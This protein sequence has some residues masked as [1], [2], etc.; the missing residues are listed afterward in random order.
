MTNRLFFFIS[1]GVAGV[2]YGVLCIIAG[3]LGEYVG[4][5]FGHP[6]VGAG[7]ASGLIGF[8]CGMF[9]MDRSGHGDPL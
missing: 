6:I 8:L 7:L 9:V 1:W 3:V 2:C 5:F 4:Q